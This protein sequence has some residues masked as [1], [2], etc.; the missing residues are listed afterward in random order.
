MNR[1]CAVVITIAISVV[2]SSCFKDKGCPYVDQQYTASSSEVAYLQNYFTAQ[3]I[4]DLTQHSS[5]VFYK[6]NQQGNGPAP[7]LCS[8]MLVTYY[9]YRLGYTNSF[10][11]YTDSTG[12]PFVLGTLITGIQKV[13]PV[14]K[15]GSSVTMY[16][17][18]S[19]AYGGQDQRDQLGNIVLPSNSYIRFDMHLKSV[20]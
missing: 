10:D 3:N 18:P 16:I 8:T 20:Q 5:G 15:A 19:L 14:I 2:F 17:P 1:I 6:I 9:A 7:G 4:T 13:M 11:Q 12:I